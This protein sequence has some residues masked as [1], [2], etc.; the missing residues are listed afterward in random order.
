MSA[1]QDVTDS[2]WDSAVIQSDTP[3]LVDFWAPW[4]GPCK[5]Q[6]P[7]LERLAKANDDITV[8]K[9]NIDESPKIASTYGI[10]SIPTLAIFHGGKAILAKAGL[11]NL[12][13]LDKLLAFAR[14]KAA[15]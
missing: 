11:Q 4:C 10:K 5:A 7:V 8:V 15:N 1:A 6:S 9:V 13:A 12:G 14:K 2:T 3:V